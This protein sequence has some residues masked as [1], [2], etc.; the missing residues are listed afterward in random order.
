MKGD[1]EEGTIIMMMKKKTCNQH[2]P[3]FP[4]QNG[5]YPST[6]NKF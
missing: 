1:I 4:T 6:K 5:F 3:I 2:F